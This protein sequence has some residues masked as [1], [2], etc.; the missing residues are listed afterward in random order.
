MNAI[1]VN[2]LTKAFGNKTKR[3][4][5]LNKISFDVKKGSI[6]GFLGPNGA[7]KSTTMNVLLGFIKATSGTAHIFDEVVDLDAVG[8][9]SSLGF[10]SN[11][12]SLDK[13]LTVG[14]ELEFLGNLSHSFDEDYSKR[15]ADRLSLDWNAKIGDL[16]TGNY[17]K[18]GI[19]SALQTRPELLILDEPTNGL[20]PLVQ[21]EFNKMIRELNAT[22][23]TVFIS[24]HILSE[25][26]E[27]CDEF[28]F[29]KKGKIAA[30]MTHR[31]IE[32]QSG[33]VLN[34]KPTNENR[35]KVLN[36]LNKNHIN[37]S[38]ETGDLEQTFMEFYDQDL[39]SD[40]KHGDR[41]A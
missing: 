28:I 3:V 19:V 8:T 10:L 18:V 30:H 14:Q 34:V 13:T 27:L 22:G 20:D 25:V 6:I 2:N 29:I 35:V 37:Y 15:L 21:A 9:R 5:A 4:L 39:A 36:F 33:Q 26:S 23:S 17:Q 38:I 41:D 31:E 11:N 7:G 24:S 1:S 32:A 16:S 40:Y 12:F